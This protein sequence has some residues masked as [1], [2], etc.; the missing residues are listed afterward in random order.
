MNPQIVRLHTPVE[1]REIERQILS[2]Q[3][4]F[5]ISPLYWEDRVEWGVKMSVGVT[6]IGIMKDVKESW[7]VSVLKML[8]LM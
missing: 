8:L 1:V 5:M 3:N 6:P 4:T 2:E 7:F